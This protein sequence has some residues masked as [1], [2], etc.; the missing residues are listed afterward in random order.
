MEEAYKLSRDACHLTPVAIEGSLTYA[1]PIFGGKESDITAILA[2]VINNDQIGWN[3][4]QW[5]T[6]L[7]L[8]CTSV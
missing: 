7:S 2:T 3:V 4:V 1:D 5:S 8:C 6:I